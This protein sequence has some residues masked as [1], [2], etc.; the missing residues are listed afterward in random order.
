MGRREDDQF[1]VVV[2]DVPEVVPS[3]RRATTKTLDKE[4][5]D[6]RI[7]ECLQRI[8][9]IKKNHNGTYPLDI[10]ALRSES[11]ATL[12]NK[13]MSAEIESA[14]WQISKI[15]SKFLS[16]TGDFRKVALA[17][18]CGVDSGQF[19]RALRTRFSMPP[20]ALAVFCYRYY[21]KTA[22]ELMF[23]APMPT[24]LPRYLQK[25]ALA[26]NDIIQKDSQLLLE[27]YVGCVSTY[28]NDEKHALPVK[29]GGSPAGTAIRIL[30]ERL[31]EIADDKYCLP[32]DATTN[33]LTANTRATIKKI[34]YD[35][36][37]NYISS[38]FFMMK[39][40]IEYETTL[41][42]LM[43]QNYAEIGDL[44]VIAKDGKQVIISDRYV[45]GIIGM[46]LMMSEEK[47]QEYLGK[48]LS[49]LFL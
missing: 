19:A 40:A 1:E 21:H 11:V 35:G 29:E 39:L 27:L 37:N 2:K 31:Y 10:E 14:R 48:T 9:D 26:L 22:H 42:Y 17:E 6:A 15:V 16:D 8:E 41:D 30:R 33:F 43:V 45:K 13:A 5:E 23:G 36:E 24:P 20:D 3:K 46:T 44:S 18:D 28:S 25:F 34:L 49:K 38:I 12:R 47:R 32:V 7:A 4:A